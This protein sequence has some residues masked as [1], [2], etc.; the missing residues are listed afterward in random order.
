[1]TTP[2]EKTYTQDDM[3]L[4]GAIVTANVAWANQTQSALDKAYDREIE[5][6]RSAFQKLYLSLEKIQDKAQRTDLQALLFRFGGDMN[7]SEEGLEWWKPKE[8]QRKRQS[9]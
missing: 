4:F 5:Q 2:E 6:W 8:E 1:M 3:S 7:H 9:W